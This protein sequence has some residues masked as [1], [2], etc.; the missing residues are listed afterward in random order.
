MQI[1]TY[2]WYA[3]LI[4]WGFFL[5]YCM[6]FLI[7]SACAYW[8]YQSQN[9]SV[10]RGINNI[11]Y[12]LGSICFGAIVITIITILRILAQS[13][14]GNGPARIVAALAACI[15]SCIEDLIKVLNN[16][17]II[18]MAVTGENYVDSAKSTISLIFDNLSLFIILDYFS[19]FYN[20]FTTFFIGLVPAFIGAGIIYKTY[21]PQTDPQILTYA[22]W[23]GIIIFLL[24][25]VISSIVI[26]MMI[27][28][29]SCIYVF[30]CFDQKFRGMGIQVNNVPK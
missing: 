27:Q 8:Y 24:S 17:S 4:F 5:Y 19:N 7:A 25:I 9:N 21:D 11:K 23:G 16:Y 29:L 12:H 28:A 14:K 3:D 2:V 15:L 1:L 20:L 26:G 13:K 18:V 30:Y 6:T 22:I 10:L